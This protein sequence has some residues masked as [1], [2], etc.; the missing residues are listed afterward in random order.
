MSATAFAILLL[1]LPGSLQAVS[2]W[3]GPLCGT[4]QDEPH[5]CCSHAP[6]PAADTEGWQRPCCCAVDLPPAQEER[7]APV[8]SSCDT[9]PEIPAAAF[10]FHEAI[11]S[12]HNPS[13]TLTLRRP[14]LRAPPT[15]LLHLFQRLLL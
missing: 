15:G 12:G 13:P 8:R 10:C 9:G 1:L 2:A 4:S 7:P 3:A 14:P 6:E 11:L 5:C